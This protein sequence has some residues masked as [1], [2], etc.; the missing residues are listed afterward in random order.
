MGTIYAARLHCHDSPLLPVFSLKLP[1]Y[2]YLPAIFDSMAAAPLS[3][4]ASILIDEMSS[5][6][7][8]NNKNKVDVPSSLICTSYCRVLLHLSGLLPRCESQGYYFAI[9]LDHL[10]LREHLLLAFSSTT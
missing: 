10:S 6:P 8:C 5:Q 2:L 7:V 3:Y 9:T 1:L 4:T